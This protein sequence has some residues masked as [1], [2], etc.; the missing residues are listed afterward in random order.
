MKSQHGLILME[1]S[2]E[3][4]LVSQ[5]VRKTSQNGDTELWTDIATSASLEG[6]VCWFPEGSFRWFA[7]PLFKNEK[8]FEHILRLL[9]GSHPN[10][11]LAIMSA[12]LNVFERPLPQTT[13][14]VA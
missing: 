14:E 4:A 6:C 1:V 9:S 8:G 3:Y 12:L 10:I 11:L 2:S 7:Q 5:K 13:A